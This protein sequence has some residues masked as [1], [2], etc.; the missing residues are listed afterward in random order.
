MKTKIKVVIGAAAIVITAVALVFATPI[1]KLTS[2][3]LAVGNQKADIHKTGTA[4]T[5]NGEPF[6]VELETAGPSTFSIQAAAFSVGGQNG[7]HSHP[8]MVAVTVLSGTIE[9]FDENCNSTVYKAGDSWVEGSQIHAFRNIGTGTV[10]LMASFITAK[11][12]PLR[13]DQAA[14]AC[15]AGLGL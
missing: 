10:Q 7:W 5:S 13:I 3:L 14:P 11:G 1:V 9:W 12:Q 2:P 15:A 4:A 6:R 8:G